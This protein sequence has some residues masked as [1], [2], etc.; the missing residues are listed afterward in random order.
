[1]YKRN[2]LRFFGLGLEMEGIKGEDEDECVHMQGDVQVDIK[3][4]KIC[5]C[6]CVCVCVC[7]RET[8]PTFGS[9]ND[10]KFGITDS[11]NDF[12]IS[13]QSGCYVL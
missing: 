5:V 7:C 3:C 9:F 8:A 6:V 4:R 10:L 13:L 11:L 12:L 2:G 1:M